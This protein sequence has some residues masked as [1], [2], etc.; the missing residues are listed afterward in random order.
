MSRCGIN[1]QVVLDA[2]ILYCIVKIGLLH[3]TK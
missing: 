2:G 1:K 3:D